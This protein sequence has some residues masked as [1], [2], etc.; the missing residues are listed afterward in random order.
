MFTLCKICIILCRNIPEKQRLVSVHFECECVALEWSCAS[1]AK[2]CCY[3]QYVNIRCAH[4]SEGILSVVAGWSVAPN[5]GS[6]CLWLYIPTLWS[7]CPLTQFSLSQLNYH[8]TSQTS[9]S[10]LA[11]LWSETAITT[12]CEIMV[13][14]KHERICSEETVPHLDV[15]VHYGYSGRLMLGL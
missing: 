14:L 13:N 11:C 10:F 8:T 6:Y 5:K 4:I 3:I 15:W 12:W 7:T 9:H 2:L 1:M